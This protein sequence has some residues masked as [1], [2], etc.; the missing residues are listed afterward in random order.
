MKTKE[1]RTFVNYSDVI[2]HHTTQEGVMDICA[3][4]HSLEMD[5]RSTL[6]TAIIYRSIQ[7][8]SE[9]IV[10]KEN[11]RK[12]NITNDVFFLKERRDGLVH[13]FYRMDGNISL[14]DCIQDHYQFF[15]FVPLSSADEGCLGYDT[16]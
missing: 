14:Y 1:K 6:P 13:Q 9:R 2:Q 4:L 16:V 10:V 15:A 3:L 12:E 5:I 11:V 8:T 7:V